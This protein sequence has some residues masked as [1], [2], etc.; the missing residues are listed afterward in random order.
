MSWTTQPSSDRPA[1]EAGLSSHLAGM[2]ASLAGYFR[3]RLEL[4]GMEGK[5]AAALWVKA[6]IFL[7][8]ALGLLAFGYAFLWIGLIALAA[9]LAQLPWAWCVLGAALLH[10]L[11]AAGLG[12]FI[13]VLWKKPVFPAT[14]EE[15][16][17][18][19]EWFKNQK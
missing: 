4:A 1:A 15:F 19:Q 18:D 6:I 17:K 2:L 16:R 14:L 9:S 8:A 3:A 7:V 13:T 5:E 10:L 11:G 12:F